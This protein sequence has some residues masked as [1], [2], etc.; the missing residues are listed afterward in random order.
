MK[1]GDTIFHQKRVK[2]ITSLPNNNNGNRFVM[3]ESQKPSYQGG[4]C[5]V[6]LWEE[7]VQ[8]SKD[9]AEK[10]KE[11]SMYLVNKEKRRGLS[12]VRYR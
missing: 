6:F 5:T 7:W 4:G 9:Q 3:W 1:V 12:V 11:D 2:K 8:E 10:D